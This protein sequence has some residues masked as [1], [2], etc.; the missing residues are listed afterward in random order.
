MLVALP[1]IHLLFIFKSIYPHIIFP[2]KSWQL[3]L[4]IRYFLPFR[5][6]LPPKRIQTFLPNLSKPFIII[7]IYT[8]PFGFKPI[9]I[10]MLKIWISISILSYQY[11]IFRNLSHSKKFSY[12]F[13]FFESII[14]EFLRHIDIVYKMYFFK[15]FFIIMF[16]FFFYI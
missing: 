5:Q 10:I 12:S 15:K 6:P 3:L 16:F 7:Q 1:I 14:P 2:I 8:F 4:T 11:S 13:P 9:L